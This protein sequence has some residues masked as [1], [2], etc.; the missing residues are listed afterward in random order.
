MTHR[1]T[2]WSKYKT[3]GTV[4]AFLSVFLA[5]G[6]AFAADAYWVVGGAGANYYFVP[7]AG[8]QF[9]NDHE[10]VLTVRDLAGADFNPQTNAPM[11]LNPT[12]GTE[13]GNRLPAAG[14]S[15]AVTP[16][17]DR[18]KAGEAKIRLTFNRNHTD[19][20]G[21]APRKF[22]TVYKWV[23]S[24][25]TPIEVTFSDDIA[26]KESAGDT[27]VP[28]M[29]YKDLNADGD[30]TD[31]GEL[32]KPV[33]Y[34]RNT[35]PKVTVKFDVSPAFAGQTVW[36]KGIGLSTNVEFK[37]SQ[38]AGATFTIT[39]VTNAAQKVRDAIAID[40]ATISWSV[41]PKE[42]EP[43]AGEYVSI[44]DTSPNAKLYIV[45]ATPSGSMSSPWTE[46]L[47]YACDWAKTRT[48]NDTDAVFDDIWG[49]LATRSATSYKY[50]DSEAPG[51]QLAD[52]VNDAD[53]RCGAWGQFMIALNS[54]HGIA[55]TSY[56]V[57]PT[58]GTCPQD[59]KRFFV[60][61]LTHVAGNPWT[62]HKDNLAGLPDSPNSEWP[63]QA[64]NTGVAGQRV[65]T[66]HKKRFTDHALIEYTRSGGSK[67]LYDPSYGAVYQGATE[68]E[69][70][71]AWQNASIDY[72]GVDDLGAG[73]FAINANP[74]TLKTQKK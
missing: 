58:D 38:T 49:K 70:M 3:F 6:V 51:F 37:T 46:V 61:N 68:N 73:I 45:L 17:A 65:A 43:A 21:T 4:L 71:L 16:T 50:Y 23:V 11:T 60:K 62:S 15:I 32:D 22:S 2:E 52:L 47:D 1:T 40:S 27:D 8:E 66:P 14:N 55:T 13:A 10:A 20:A 57:E 67:R 26:L 69:R 74:G 53:G 54:C 25:I 19:P 35:A 33:C 36:V 56:G 39:D 41:C 12:T 72:F 5:A 9:P 30:A 63:V 42:T 28:T 31:T 64:P 59:E 7:V 29:V 24:R 48:T 34:V 44:G 18:A